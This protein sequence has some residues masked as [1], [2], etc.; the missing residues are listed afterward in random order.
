MLHGSAFPVVM[1]IFG[2]L[3][4]SFIDQ[5]ITLELVQNNTDIVTGC[6]EQLLGPNVTGPST[7]VDCDA[8]FV[9]GNMSATLNDIIPGCFGEGRM[10]LDNSAFTDL[11]VTQCYIYAGIATAVFIISGLQS[12]LFQYVAERQ[13]HQIRQKFY[14][15]ILRQDIG[16]FDANPSGELSSRL[17]E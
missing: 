8:R 10:C 17:S 6:L 7:R 1:L 14:R 12:F 16:W 4:D 2:Q 11:I 15:A 3:T 5:A 13:I 9:S